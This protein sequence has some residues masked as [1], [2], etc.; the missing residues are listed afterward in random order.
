MFYSDAFV[1]DLAHLKK[2]LNSTHIIIRVRY[3]Q[4]A[5]TF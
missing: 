5:C 1:T 2:F 4:Q 3:L